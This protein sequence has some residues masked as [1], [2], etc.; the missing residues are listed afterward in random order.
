MAAASDPYAS[1]ADELRGTSFSRIRYVESTA[2]TNDDAAALLGEAAALGTTFVADYQTRG[3]GR[4]GRSWVAA[5]GTALLATTILPRSMPAA[6]LWIV[7]FGVAVCRSPR[8]RKL[9]HQGAASLAER[10]ACRRTRKSLVSCAFRG[11]SATARGSR[12]GSASTSTA[13]PA[14]MKA[15]IR[16]RPSR[17]FHSGDRSRDG[18]TQ[19]LL[20]Y[21]MWHAQ[22][23][24]PQRIARVWER[25]AGLPG[26][27]YRILKDNADEPIEV[28]ALSLH[29]G[30]GLVVQHDDGR[31]E[32]IDLADA[33]ALR[34][35][36]WRRRTVQ[37][38][39][40]FLERRDVRVHHVPRFVVPEG[41]M[42][43]Q[44]RL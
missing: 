10:Y 23:D 3:T 39:V 12:P 14:P 7:P 35:L 17:R 11:S 30:G 29:T 38:C 21:D 33:R 13:S 24:M 28:T 41:D 9:R 18:A 37:V 26:V 16:L 22:L 44:R 19:H 42:R 31:K 43:A 36:A 25:Q 1:L 5:P 15:S 34:V 4:K 27:R 32:T 6:N 8:A 20:N 2:S 40:E